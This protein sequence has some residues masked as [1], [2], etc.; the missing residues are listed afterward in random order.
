MAQD[1]GTYAPTTEDYLNRRAEQL[2]LEGYRLLADPIDD[3]RDRSAPAALRFYQD[4]LGASAGAEAAAALERFM[5][6]LNT[7]AFRPLVAYR[8]GS[9]FISPDEVLLLGIVAGIQHWDEQIF[10]VCLTQL[11]PETSLIKVAASAETFAATLR[12]LGVV[13]APLPLSLRARITRQSETG[14]RASRATKTLH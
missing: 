3:M 14:L 2:V 10:R 11:C 4:K 7:C 9:R 5:T 1:T 6:S 12:N 8:A 13:L